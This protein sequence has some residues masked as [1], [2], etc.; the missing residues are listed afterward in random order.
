MR[1]NRWTIPQFRDNSAS[2]IINKN[3]VHY[4]VVYI[5][6]A[7]QQFINV[8]ILQVS[9]FGSKHRPGDINARQKTSA[10]RQ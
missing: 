4:N 3:G 2:F 9:S 8:Q 1:F 5:R 6:K 10:Y 7:Q